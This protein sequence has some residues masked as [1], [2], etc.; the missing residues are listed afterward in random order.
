MNQTTPKPWPHDLIQLLTWQGE[1]LDALAEKASHQSRLIEAGRIDALL[2]LLTD[3]QALVEE[4]MTSKERM[5]ALTG[6]LPARIDALDAGQRTE[7]V[8][9][10]ERIGERFTRVMEIDDR[11]RRSIESA[12]DET[13]TE[14]TTFD[15]ARL[16]RSAYGQRPAGAPPV[17][18]ADQRG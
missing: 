11:D 9:L 6:D 14:L 1:L 2:A 3:R 5:A 12:R 4:L 8:T 15:T 10:I 18:F 13:R 7:L 17:R 16:A